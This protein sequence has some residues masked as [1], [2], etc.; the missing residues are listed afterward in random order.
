[1]KQR[2]RPSKSNMKVKLNP[3]PPSF[4]CPLT[5]EVMEDP[6]RDTCA[7][8]FERKAI[9]EWVERHQCCP[10]SRKELT[11]EELIPNHTLAERID[12]WQW[13]QHVDTSAWK[14]LEDQTS[15]ESVDEESESPAILTKIPDL[16]MG[17]R[18]A[19]GNYQE[20]PSKFMFLPQE[21]E[22]MDLVRVQEEEHRKSLRTQAW[23]TCICSTMMIIALVVLILAGV[24][25]I[26][27]N[28][29][30]DDE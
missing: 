25:L 2:K 5:Y 15:F 7:H 9:V 16:E 12:R 13:Q 6:V 10:I 4:V 1:M 22:A 24:R 18:H 21:L 29:W 19:K 8:N 14:E 11:L 30:D 23:K 26:R 28:Q 17:R 27:E 20:V 3:H